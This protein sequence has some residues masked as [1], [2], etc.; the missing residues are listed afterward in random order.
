MPPKKAD[1][2]VVTKRKFATQ[3]KIHEAYKNE[4]ANELRHSDIA[5]TRLQY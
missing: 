3:L 1:S 2:F 5:S 4:M